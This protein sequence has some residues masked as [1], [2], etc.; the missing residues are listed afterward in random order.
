MVLKPLYIVIILLIGGILILSSCQP[1]QIIYVFDPVFE[2]WYLKE[3]AND[4][5]FQL[6]HCDLQDIYVQGEVELDVGIID[7]GFPVTYETGNY[8]TFGGVVG[9]GNHGDKVVSASGVRLHIYG[10]SGL[11]EDDILL[12]LNYMYDKGVRRVSLSAGRRSPSMKLYNWLSSHK[13]LLLYASAGNDRVIEYP[14]GFL[15]VVGVGSV[16]DD[17]YIDTW[18]ARDDVYYNGY[19]G[20]SKGTSFSSPRA[21]V[22]G[23]NRQM[24]I[25]DYLNDEWILAVEDSRGNYT[26]YEN[27]SVGDSISVPLLVFNVW[28]YKDRDN[29]GG[30][31][32]GDLFGVARSS[33]VLK[34][35]YYH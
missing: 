9:S 6:H 12:G 35:S 30:L 28:C 3:S 4:E 33:E 29:S 19:I 22:D 32:L 5:Q 8:I 21:M 16:N 31:S 20:D 14:A 27:V 1:R 11:T 7:M 13:D 26:Y 34:V 15:S 17:G 25:H 24:N 18:S 2:E 23:E 10:L